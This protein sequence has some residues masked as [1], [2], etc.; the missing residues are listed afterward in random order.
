MTP[1]TNAV[2]SDTLTANPNAL[3]S[4]LRPRAWESR[5]PNPPK[6]D[7]NSRHSTPTTAPASASRMLGQQLLDET[8]GWRRSPLAGNARARFTREEEIR[9]VDARDEQQQANGRAASTRGPEKMT[10]S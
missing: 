1:N 2:T 3:T 5:L 7:A 8:P 10:T 4:I 6:R 9:D